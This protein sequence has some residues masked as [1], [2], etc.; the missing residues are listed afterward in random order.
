M[1]DGEVHQH[2]RRLLLQLSEALRSHALSPAEAGSSKVKA[3][4]APRHAEIMEALPVAVYATDAAGRITFYNGAAATLWGRHPVLGKDRWCGS[5][6]MY[7]PDGT[8]LPHDC[9]PMAVAIKERRA[10]RNVA[11]VAERPDG[12]RVPFMP[13]ATPLQDASGTLTGAVNVLV[14]INSLPVSQGTD[15]ARTGV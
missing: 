5:W 2:V 13:F 14:E 10:V 15:D 7:L 1:P 12:T 9:C 6:R 8:P 3:F 11:A 4:A